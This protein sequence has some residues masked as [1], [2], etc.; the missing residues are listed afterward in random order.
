MNEGQEKKNGGF[1]KFLG[2]VFLIIL[3]VGGIVFFAKCIINEASDGEGNTDGNPV[4]LNRAATLN[5]FTLTESVEA[6][7]T[8]LKESYI[9]VSN[10]DIKNLEITFKYYDSSNNLIATKIK[11]VCNVIKSSEYIV[12]IEHS[13][14]EIFTMATVSYYVSGGTVSY[15]G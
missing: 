1:L 15:F 3:I 11:N 12:S 4:F 5:D 2:I 8:N 14:T 7:I 13:L 6:T 10:V 9:L